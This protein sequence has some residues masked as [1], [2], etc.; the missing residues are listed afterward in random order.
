MIF[1]FLQGNNH[2]LEHGSVQQEPQIEVSC[3]LYVYLDISSSVFPILER[4]S[5]EPQLERSRER[6]VIEQERAVLDTERKYMELIDG[7]RNTLA[8]SRDTAAD[9]RVKLAEMEKAKAPVRN[10]QREKQKPPQ[11][12]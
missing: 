9:L 6:A 7:L 2:Y 3:G 8:E 10:R 1:D 5:A 11:N 4:I 12:S